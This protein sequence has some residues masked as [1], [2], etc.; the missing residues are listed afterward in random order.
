[1]IFFLGKGC[2]HCIQQLDA[3]T[4]K[5][6]QIEE[7]GLTVVTVSIDDEAAIKNMWLPTAPPNIHS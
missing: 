3:F 6:K 4:K 1:M 2:P 5:A 7:A